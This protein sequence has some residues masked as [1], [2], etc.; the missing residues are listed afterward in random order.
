MQYCE[1]KSL[2]I[3]G[4]DLRSLFYQINT[5]ACILQIGKLYFFLFVWF[6]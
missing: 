6:L 4:I 2:S 3:Y 1:S 5:I